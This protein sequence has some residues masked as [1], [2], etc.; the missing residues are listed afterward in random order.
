MRKILFVFFFLLSTL[1]FSVYIHPVF[2]ADYFTVSTNVQ[3]SVK[4]TATTSVSF[5]FLLTNTTSQYYAPSY[6]IIVGFNNISNVQAHDPDGPITPHITETSD[7]KKIELVFNS[8]SV[9]NGKILPFVLSFDTE[10]VAS[11]QGNIWEVNVPGIAGKN[12]FSDFTQ[13]ITVP[14]SFGIPAYVKPATLL[15]V[16]QVDNTTL[17]FTKDQL[18]KAGISIA[19]GNTQTYAFSL[20][21]HLKNNNLF[22]VKTEIA[23]PPT[24][25][26]QDVSIDT[27]SPQPSNVIIDKDGNWLAQYSL[28]SSEKKDI[29]VVGKAKIYLNPKKQPLLA[30]DE[31]GYLSQKQYWDTNDQVVTNVARGLKTPKQIYDYVVKTLRYDFSRVSDGKPR[32]GA[33][34]VLENPLSAVC[35]EFTDLFI[36]LARADGIPAR[37][38][39]GF[40]YTKNAK[41]RPLSLVKD[42]LH[43]WPEYYDKTQQTWVMVDPTWEN[44]TGGVDYFNTFDFDHFAFV[45]KG[46]DSIYPIPPGGYKISGSEDTKDVDVSITNDSVDTASKFSPIL[47]MPSTAFSLLPIFGSLT[48]RNTGTTLL[49]PQTAD[50]SSDLSPVH[51]VINFAGIPPYGMQSMQLSFNKEP[52]LTNRQYEVTIQLGQSLQKT[53]IRVIPFFLSQTFL[54]GGGIS[55]AIFIIIIS[56][57]AVSTGRLHFFRQE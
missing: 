9:G 5:Q 13:Q 47:A 39:D 30:N 40:A 15:S 8:R 49:L 44:T 50:V 7:G 57:I 11:K 16:V 42:V 52:L 34:N 32:L 21:Y 33:K 56:I 17:R 27:I 25:N 23:L 36:S 12:D 38:V 2:A 31:S 48:I 41:Q 3:Y 54:I 55:V 22:P 53:T 51:Q 43:A 46:Q 4:E 28:S 45:I 24:T 1:F 20:S 6:S 14:P 26:Y 29:T 35:L 19:Y 10:D 18:G 37:E